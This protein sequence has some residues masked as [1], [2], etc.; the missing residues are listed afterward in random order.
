[1]LAGRSNVG[2]STLLN[3][4]IGTKVAIT[5]PKPQTTRQPMRGILNDDRG[6]VVFV[7][8][9]GV[10]LGKKDPVSKKLNEFV[11]ETLKGV[12]LILYVVDPTREYGQEEARIQ[13]MLRETDIPKLVVI[14]KR[15]LPE[16]KRPFTEAYR[17]IDVGQIE[18]VEVSATTHNNLNQLVSLVFENLPEGEPYYPLGQM[19]D[20]AQPEW[21]EEIVREKVYLSLSEELPYAVT[22]RFDDMETKEDGTRVFYVTILTTSE[23]HKRMIIGSGARKIKEIGIQARKELETALQ[24]KVFLDL[25]VKVDA[26]WP[27]RFG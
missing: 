17:D 16:R 13:A 23:R 27:E 12:D 7:D 2:K 1:M 3:A 15:D 24:A 20:L 8:T 25:R 18:T 22:V 14:N 26:H 10:F 21:I 4:L 19:T 11:R 5:T 6:Q 9:P